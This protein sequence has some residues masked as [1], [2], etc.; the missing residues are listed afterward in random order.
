MSQLLAD[1]REL[2][3]SCIAGDA[4]SQRYCASSQPRGGD[5]VFARVS[6]PR[7]VGTRIWPGRGRRGVSAM[8]TLTGCPEPILLSQLLDRELAEEEENGLR[9]HVET[10]IEVTHALIN[11]QKQKHGPVRI[12]A[13]SSAPFRDVFTGVFLAG[14]RFRLC[15]APVV[16]GWAQGSRAPSTH[17][18]KMS[19]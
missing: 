11:W 15:A 16:R 12:T 13:C 2:I 14:M 3:Q 19:R 5:G 9:R 10:C 7:A 4:T 18:S 6:S 8:T 1:I 17:V